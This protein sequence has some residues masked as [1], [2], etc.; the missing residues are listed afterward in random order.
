MLSLAHRTCLPGSPPIRS[1][2][3][4]L[5]P[6][7]SSSPPPATW[8]RASPCTHAKSVAAL[9]TTISS[10]EPR[11]SHAR[12]R[13]V[14][15]RLRVP[16]RLP[17][18]QTQAARALHGSTGRCPTRKSTT[19]GNFA[20]KPLSSSNPRRIQCPNTSQPEVAFVSNTKSLTPTPLSAPLQAPWMPAFCDARVTRDITRG[21]PRSNRDPA[22]A[23]PSRPPHA[24]RPEPPVTPTRPTSPP[25][26]AKA[27]G[28]TRMLVV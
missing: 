22:H 7:S 23:Q 27:T 1:G 18:D 26:H 19:G 3:N 28:A 20:R 2:V 12:V 21:S 9:A 4:K 8:P 5:V 10:L 25:A 6:G 16:P 15:G 24:P 17:R 11:R 13:P 14:T